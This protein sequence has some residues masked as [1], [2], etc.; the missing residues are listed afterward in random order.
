MLAQ[1]FFKKS[2]FLNTSGIALP[3]V[4][5]VTIHDF[6]SDIRIYVIASAAAILIVYFVTKQLLLRNLFTPERPDAA[7][8][9]TD[10]EKKMVSVVLFLPMIMGVALLIAIGIFDCRL[11]KIGWMFIAMSTNIGQ[12]LEALWRLDHI[13]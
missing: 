8:D 4:L 7:M 9:G 3:I 6:D 1:E 2:L 11:S 5:Y 12:N 10:I 13:E